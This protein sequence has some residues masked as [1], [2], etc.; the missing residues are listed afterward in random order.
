MEK[1]NKTMTQVHDKQHNDASKS[2]TSNT[3]SSGC[4]TGSCSTSEKKGKTSHS[5]DESSGTC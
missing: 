1:K 2:K 3:T 4:K 5:Q